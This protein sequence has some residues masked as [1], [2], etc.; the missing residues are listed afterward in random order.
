MSDITALKRIFKAGLTKKS[1]TLYID[2]F[3]KIER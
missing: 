3:N 1:G 2:L